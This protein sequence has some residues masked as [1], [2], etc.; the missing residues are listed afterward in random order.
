MKVSEV[1]SLQFRLEEWLCEPTG[2]L[3]QLDIR[4]GGALA[5]AKEKNLGSEM[6]V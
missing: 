5:S 6:V 3:D 2:R 1:I 4:R